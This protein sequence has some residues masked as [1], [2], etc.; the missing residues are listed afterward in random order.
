MEITIKEYEDIYETSWDDFVL[1]NTLGTI[2][3]TRRFINYHPKDRFIDK[4]ILLFYK[5]ELICVLPCTIEKKCEISN[6]LKFSNSDS[7]FS[8]TGAT[9]GGPV[10]SKKYYKSKYLIYIINRIFSYYDNKIEFRLANNIYFNESSFI[11]QYLLNRKLIMK[12]ELS[13]YINIEDDFIDNI[14]NSDNKRKLKKMIKQNVQCYISQQTNDYINYY[15][16]LKLMLKRNHNTEPT[17]TL[18]EFLSLIN[19]LKSDQLLFICKENDIIL[20]GVY[21]IKVTN[22]CWYTFYISRNINFSDSSIN[23]IYIIYN[24]VNEAKKNNVKYLDYGICTENKGEYINEGLANFKEDSLGGIS[25]YR[26]LFLHPSKY[27]FPADT[28]NL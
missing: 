28:E 26:Y 9:Y 4:S 1:N 8:Y 3:H 15:N 17:H 16:I 6:E 2:Y 21:V 10:I 11:L 5:E 25:N 24:I 20:A 18:E 22:K 13:W 19:I 12:T 14:K 23:V 7:Y 27:K